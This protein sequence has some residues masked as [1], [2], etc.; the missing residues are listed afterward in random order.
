MQII[1][2]NVKDYFVRSVTN[3]Q[4]TPKE[5]VGIKLSE[6]EDRKQMIY[7][8]DKML[9]K[10]NSQIEKY[11]IENLKKLSQNQFDDIIDPLHDGQEKVKISRCHAFLLKLQQFSSVR[12]W[13][14]VVVVLL[15]LAVTVIPNLWYLVI[16]FDKYYF[17]YIVERSPR[18]GMTTTQKKYF[19]N[20]NIPFKTI[21]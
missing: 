15:F 4:L 9:E 10:V 5:A 16:T 7:C 3:I 12:N 19:M 2:E 20:N 8:R 1:K 14:A 17:G 13:M 6:E 18:L 11:R 21:E